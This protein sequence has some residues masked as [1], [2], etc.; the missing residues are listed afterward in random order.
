M[1]LVAGGSVPGTDHTMPG[2]PGWTNNQDAYHWR[3]QNSCLVA[4]VCDGCGSGAHSE[5][6][7]NLLARLVTQVIID[8]A[9]YSRMGLTMSW[10]RVRQL[11]IS[12]VTV[13][14]KAM[15]RSLSETINDFFLSTIL[16]VVVTP[17]EISVFSVGDGVYVADG[18]TV[19]LGPFPNNAPP[20][21]AYE[22]SGSTLVDEHPEYFSLCPRFSLS[23]SEPHALL[24]GTDGV[25]DLIAAAESNL[26]HR[27]EQVGPISQ[28]WEDEKKYFG[29]PD[30]IRR[31][32]ALINKE[33]AEV[34]GEN[35][36]RVTGG[37]LPDDTTFIVI[38]YEP[39][40]EKGGE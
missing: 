36:A 25:N 17:R 18:Y 6:G 40:S 5:V 21:L 39:P 4:V 11:I 27:A 22:I 29:N 34:V 9:M 14:A 28:F 15:G 19:R 12:H 30:A 33:G 13:I 16:G 31:R 23:V 7:A 26:P 32:L 8:E 35:V 2:K 24:I 3:Q 20:Y 1:I 37:L 10:M 38:K